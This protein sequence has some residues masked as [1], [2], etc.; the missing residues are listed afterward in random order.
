ML[1]AGLPPEPPAPASSTSRYSLSSPKTCTHPTGATTPASETAHK[2]RS[3]FIPVLIL[4]PEPR[5]GARAPAPRRLIER[6]LRRPA[7]GVSPVSKE[8]AYKAWK[9]AIVAMKRPNM[10]ASLERSHVLT[11]ALPPAR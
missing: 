8:R 4:P 9:V 11:V 3:V 6:S 1:L 5:G 2:Y 7:T 10:R